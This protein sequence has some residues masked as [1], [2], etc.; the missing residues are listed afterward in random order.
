[1]RKRKTSFK[2]KIVFFIVAI[3][4]LAVAMLAAFG[5]TIDGKTYVNVAKNIRF[6][7]DIKGGVSATFKAADENVTPTAEQ[8]EAAKT[9]IETRLDANN[10]LDRNVTIDSQNNYI[11]VEFPWAANEENF[12]PA[13]AIQE[14]GETAEL[15]F[16]HV[17]YDEEKQT[18]NKVEKEPIVTG[19]NVV[20]AEPGYYE[21]ENQFLVSLEFDSEGAKLF[22]DAT[23]KLV[24]KVIAIYMDDTLISAATVNEAITDGKAQITGS[25]TADDVKDLAS[26]ISAGAL[27]FSLTST[28]YSSISATLGEGALK[29]MVNAGILAFIIICL[30]MILYYRLPGFVACLNLLLQ[31]TGQLVIFATLGL[32]MTL[33]GIA[34]IILAIGMSVDT[35]IIIAENIK[36]EI[37]SGKS[38]KGAVS[39]G[40]SRAFTAVFD[41]NFTTAIVAVLLIY[42]GTGS[43]LSFGYTL[44]IGN[45]LNFCFGFFSTKLMLTSLVNFNFLCKPWL[46]GAKKQKGGAN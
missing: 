30:F 32:T 22:G 34:G 40:L 28:N 21:Q 10:I 24:D 25:F 7:I 38:V 36:D 41:C 8:L 11:L 42:L 20:K 9:I 44:I 33:P 5:V 6:G 19:A 12:D 29:V 26:K 3:V 17:E 2:Q 14:L 27:P 43:M 35:N 18:Y 37:K 4:I 1:M 31:V 15:S 16:W 39:A 13:Q 46:C 23:N 45:I